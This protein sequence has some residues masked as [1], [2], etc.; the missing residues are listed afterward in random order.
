MMHNF[1]KENYANS[2]IILIIYVGVPIT[3]LDTK[4][5]ERDGV[6]NSVILSRVH[7][8]NFT[9]NTCLTSPYMLQRISRIQRCNKNVRVVQFSSVLWLY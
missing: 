7:Q 2:V 3:S 1:H 9:K 5:G 8:I 6:Y 4:L